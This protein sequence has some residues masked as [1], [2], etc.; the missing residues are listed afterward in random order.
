MATEFVY[1]RLP[2]SDA[3]PGYVTRQA[4]DEIWE[5][6]G[7]EIVDDDEATVASTVETAPEAETKTTTRRRKA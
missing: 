6:K 4:Y 7:F 3:V 5:A 2:G 1:I